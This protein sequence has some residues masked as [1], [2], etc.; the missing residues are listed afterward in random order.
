LEIIDLFSPNV[1]DRPGGPAAVNILMLHYTGMRSAQ[2]AIDRLRDPEA[3][4]SS[5][6]VVDE[7]GAVFRLVPEELR[8]FHAGISYW[9]GRRVLNDVSVGIEIVN[10]GHEWGYRAFPAAQMEAVRVLCDGILS[11][12]AIPAR[13][14]VGHSDVAP[15]RKQDPGELFDWR[16][17]AAC[18]IGFWTEAGESAAPDEAAALAALEA[19]GYSPEFTLDVLLTAFQ[20]HFVQARVTGELDPF[21]MGRLLAIAGSIGNMNYGTP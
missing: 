9:R 13:N 16:G 1:D 15:N 17:L 10:P 18:G 20:R 6:Y 19:I 8:A 2:A 4:V 3:K 7:D 21:T 14:V 11:R 12:H 5:H